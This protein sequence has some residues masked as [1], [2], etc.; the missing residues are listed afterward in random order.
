MQK[1]N[2]VSFFPICQALA[3]NVDA[4]TGNPVN[5]LFPFHIVQKLVVVELTSYASSFAALNE[6][7]RFEY[8]DWSRNYSPVLCTFI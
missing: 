4:D 8:Y 3:L 2:H 7:L 5:S 1:R 6:K